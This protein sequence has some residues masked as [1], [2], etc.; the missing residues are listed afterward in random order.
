M[1][2]RRVL[3]DTN[4]LIDYLAGKASARAEIERETPALA[5][6]IARAILE[7]PSSLR[8]GAAQ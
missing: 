6:Q 8:G 2:V 5:N 1:G 7:K 4:I 3:L